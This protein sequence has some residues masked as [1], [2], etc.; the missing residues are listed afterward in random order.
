VPNSSYSS[1]I[2]TKGVCATPEAMA[3]VAWG[4][5]TPL[6]TTLPYPGAAA[7]NPW[8]GY[9]Y[10]HTTTMPARGARSPHPLLILMQWLFVGDKEERSKP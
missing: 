6:I 1:H 4:L 2:L 8:G 3:S 9:V 5:A 10:N 7:M